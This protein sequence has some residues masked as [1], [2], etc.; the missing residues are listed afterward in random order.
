MTAKGHI[1]AN[2]SDC[3]A[4]RTL[5]NLVVLR[6]LLPVEHLNEAP[7]ERSAIRSA[8]SSS[9]MY[10]CELKETAMKPFSLP[11]HEKQT[12]SNRRGEMINF[13]LKLA[14]NLHTQCRQTR[15][16]LYSCNITTPDG[17][18]CENNSFLPRLTEIYRES[19]LKTRNKK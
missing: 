19:G 1:L 9:Q 5:P 4:A 6:L 18:L 13:C 8:L 17:C 15:E 2:T 7:P 10:I 14:E 3:C 11:R 16:C 12:L